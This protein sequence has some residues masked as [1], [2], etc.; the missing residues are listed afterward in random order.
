M[1][2]GIFQRSSV[3][4]ALLGLAS[5]AG[6]PTWQAVARQTPRDALDALPVPVAE[7]E[8]LIAADTASVTPTSP[9]PTP[10]FDALLP[11][12]PAPSS[13]N[14]SQQTPARRPPPTCAHEQGWDGTACVTRTCAEGSRF[15]VVR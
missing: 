2:A 3:I 5:C 10:M 9:A 14:S 1:S 13:R 6:T 7:H 4:L 12:L 11:P 8:S 15:E